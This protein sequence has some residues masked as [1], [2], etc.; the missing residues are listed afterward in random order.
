[1]KTLETGEV[2]YTMT[3]D[4]T[5]VIGKANWKNYEKDFEISQFFKIAGFDLDYCLF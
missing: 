4:R 1:M 5:L 3:D 2:T